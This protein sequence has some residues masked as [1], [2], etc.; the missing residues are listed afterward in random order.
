MTGR[1]FD[2]HIYSNR[3]ACIFS[4]WTKVLGN[5]ILSFFLLC[6]MLEPLCISSNPQCIGIIYW[7]A[8]ID[9]FAQATANIFFYILFSPHLNNF[10]RYFFFFSCF[11]KTIFYSFL[12]SHS[13]TEQLWTKS[14]LWIFVWIKKN[15]PTLTNR[16]FVS[17]TFFWGVLTINFFFYLLHCVSVNFIIHFHRAIH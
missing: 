1:I 7:Y 16:S 6:T 9:S 14:R 8:Y 15:K 5:Q 11:K 10:F 12:F 3:S 2:V 17:F 4:S 13:H